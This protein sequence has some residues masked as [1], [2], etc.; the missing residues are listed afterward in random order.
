VSS[1][2]GVEERLLCVV[3][4]AAVL[5]ETDADWDKIVDEIWVTVSR[6]AAVIKRMKD[7]RAMTEEQTKARIRAQMSNEEKIKRSSVVI[8][9]DG[10][11]E[12]MKQEV[13]KL[14]NSLVD[15]PQ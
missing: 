15:K 6:E 10:S 1:A 13:K 2:G 4:E 14:W 5:L 3:L 7:Q 12:E 8:N 11:L 9:N